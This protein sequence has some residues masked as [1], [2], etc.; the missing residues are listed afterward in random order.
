MIELIVRSKPHVWRNIFIDS[1][2][3]VESGEENVRTA[4][5]NKYLRRSVSVSFKLPIV[6]EDHLFFLR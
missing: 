6:C 3:G 5:E 4:W 1:L 2:K